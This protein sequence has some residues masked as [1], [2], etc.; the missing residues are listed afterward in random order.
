MGL[1]GER[2]WGVAGKSVS[3]LAVVAVCAVLFAFAF[4]SVVS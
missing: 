3:S 4:G 2:V 1:V